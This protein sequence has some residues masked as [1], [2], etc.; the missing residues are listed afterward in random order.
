MARKK[1]DG[2]GR[3]GGRSVGTPNKKTTELKE[4]VKNL[5]ESNQ[6]TFEKDLLAIKDPKDRLQIMT[7]LLK[8]AIA[9]AQSIPPEVE[10]NEIRIIIVE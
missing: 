9:P 8:Y 4:W 3:I 6:S 2:L 5:L 7:S 1:N 10:D